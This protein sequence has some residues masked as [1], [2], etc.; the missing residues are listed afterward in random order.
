MTASVAWQSS[1][2]FQPHLSYGCFACVM[3]LFVVASVDVYKK[4][5]RPSA[6][7][8]CPMSGAVQRCSGFLSARFPF[9]PGCRSS[10]CRVALLLW[11]PALCGQRFARYSQRGGFVR[12]VR[13]HKFLEKGFR[14][15][16]TQALRESAGIC[17]PLIFSSAGC[18]N[19]KELEQQ[20][21][22]IDRMI[23]L[24]PPRTR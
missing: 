6:Y 22:S 2:F 5:P 24:K 15:F 12:L 14:A 18:R 4:K 20:V 21:C 10:R 3:L 16:H 11:F 9:C 23:Y 19:E 17:F 1:R 8:P 7:R 13:A